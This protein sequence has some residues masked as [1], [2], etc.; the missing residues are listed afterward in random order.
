MSKIIA[1]DFD[2]TCVDHCYPKIGR[3]VPDAVEGLNTLAD[4]GYKFILSTMRSGETLGDAVQWFAERNISLFGVQTHPTQHTWTTSPKCHADLR[5]DDGNVGTPLV[6]Y[7]GFN[8]PCVQWLNRVVDG[9]V[10]EG[11]V[12]QVLTREVL[13]E[14][15]AISS[16]KRALYSDKPINI[17][18]KFQNLGYTYVEQHNE[19]AACFL[20]G[21]HA[22]SN[23]L[24][25]ENK[26]IVLCDKCGTPRGT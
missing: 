22:F 20:C 11:V 26:P 7:L 21:S 5:I 19:R 18:L 2:A 4:N 6:Q 10:Y 8:A 15:G 24:T 9:V 14:Y 16:F 13:L 3:D 25:N 12:V 17:R 1:L 23:W